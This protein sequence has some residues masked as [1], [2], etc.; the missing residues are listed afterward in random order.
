LG[1]VAESLLSGSLEALVFDSLKQE[2]R[3]AEFSKVLAKNG[4]SFQ[5]ALA[6]A[7]FFGG[8]MY[9]LH[10]LLPYVACAL[11]NAIAAGLAFFFIEPRIDTQKFTLA[12]Y[13]LQMKEGAIHAFAT[14][15]VAMMS[16]FY[17]FVSAITWS[18]NLYFFDFMLVD[19]QFSDTQRS[20]IGGSIRLL[21]ISILA[22]L[23]HNEHIFTRQR[24]MLF[25]PIMMILCFLP[26]IFFHGW[27][28]LPFIAGAVMAGSARWIVL[29][30]YTNELF[31]SKY[32]ATAVS[33]LSML[34]GVLYV[35]I[36]MSSGPLIEYFGSIKVLYTL[37]G[38]ATIFTVLPLS[39]VVAK[40]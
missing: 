13:V 11:L 6:T 39:F 10:W 26:G 32:R 20:I 18:N 35:L 22:S 14:K 17:V 30:R 31:E 28:S 15:K 27:W 38:I 9:S 19:L 37:L 25:F 3:E 1:G 29:T 4:V 16:L 40:K 12:N 34:V 23:L 7:T 33:V 2:G 36:T 5:L 8:Y 24:S 21:N